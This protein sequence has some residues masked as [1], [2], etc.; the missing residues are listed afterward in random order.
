ME[1]ANT[2]RKYFIMLSDNDT[3]NEN[4]AALTSSWSVYSSLGPRLALFGANPDLVVMM[5]SPVSKKMKIIHSIKNLGGSLTEPDNQLVGLVGMTAKAFPILISSNTTGANLDI[6][7]HL[8]VD[9]KAI[10]NDADF[11]GLV[12]KTKENYSG[13]SF[14]LLPPFLA[15]VVM[16]TKNHC[17][18]FLFQEFMA[19]MFAFDLHSPL[20][21]ERAWEKKWIHSSVSLGS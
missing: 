18:K 14:A 8:V 21:N 6:E 5:L 15:K 16:E 9:I 12:F 11:S 17:P 4:L 3:L 7:V 20:G 2:W 10:Q 19:A 13:S 1:I